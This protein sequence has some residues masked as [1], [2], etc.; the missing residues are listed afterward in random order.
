[1]ERKCLSN[2]G[3]GSPKK[4]SC[5]IISQTIDQGSHCI[6]KLGVHLVLPYSL[7]LYPQCIA[8]YRGPHHF[9]D[10]KPNFG[11]KN[12]LQ[13]VNGN[14]DRL[15]KEEKSFKGFSIFS[16]GSHFVQRSKTV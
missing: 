16:S 11:G 3:K 1:M 2:F 8:A 15:V 7:F 14:A 4:H 10:Y 6:L 9:W 5:L 13:R 12:P